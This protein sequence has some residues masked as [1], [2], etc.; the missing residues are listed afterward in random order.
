MGN[1]DGSIKAVQSSAPVMQVKEQRPNL[2]SKHQAEANSA[3]NLAEKLHAKEKE[4]AQS[5]EETLE[6]TVRKINQVLNA[7]SVEAE[8]QI[9]R[10]VNVVQVKVVDKQTG[11]LLREI[12]SDEAIDHLRRLKTIASGLFDL[13]V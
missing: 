11:K 10:D 5:A 6:E 9:H 12:P 2:T 8:F 3:A 1:P 7:L 4:A 13:Q